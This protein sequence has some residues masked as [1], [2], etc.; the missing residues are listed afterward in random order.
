MDIVMTPT[1]DPLPAIDPETL[2]LLRAN[3]ID[4][5]VFLKRQAELAVR[6]ALPSAAERLSAEQAALRPA[7]DAYNAFVDE[8]GL[9][10]DET[11]DL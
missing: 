3:G 9:F 4:P 1:A 7:L 10:A 6:P 11:R 5:M 2:A 8:H